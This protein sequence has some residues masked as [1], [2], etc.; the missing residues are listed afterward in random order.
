MLFFAERFWG[1]ED[2]PWALALSPDGKYLFAGSRLGLLVLWNFETGEEIQRFYGHSQTTFIGNVVFS[3]DGQTVFSSSFDPQ[4]V[5]IQWRF[6]DWPLDELRAWIK[7][8]H[9]VRDLTCHEREL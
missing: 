7:D 1:I 4:G 5:V 8:N 3:P 6:A 9:Y 2:T